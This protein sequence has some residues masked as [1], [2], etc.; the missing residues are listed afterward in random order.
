L[1][2]KLLRQFHDTYQ[3]TG[4]T[5]RE[6]V[7]SGNYKLAEQVLHDIKGASGNISAGNLHKAV[8]FRGK[9]ANRQD[10]FLI[11]G[12][13]LL[14]Y[15][16]LSNLIK[17]AVEA[18]PAGE[19]VEVAMTSGESAVIGIHNAGS[20]PIDIRETFFE[21]YTTSGKSGGT[22]LG[23][24]SAKLI[25]QTIGGNIKLDTSDETGTTITI[26]LPKYEL[27]SLRSQRE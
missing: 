2:K 21:K 26:V 11:Q 10:L 3:N 20:V 1:Y 4:K 19:K 14:C 23:T 9:P 22:G 6:A 18:S 12:D 24:Y 25:T 5:I 27:S 8:L 13:E 15:S 7:S 16:M 17:N